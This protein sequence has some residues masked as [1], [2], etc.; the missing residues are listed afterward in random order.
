MIFVDNDTQIKRLN[1][2]HDCEFFNIYT[3]RCKKCGCFMH[4][5]TKLNIK[6]PIGRYDAVTR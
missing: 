4:L 3:K 1:V 6:C 5:K 2:C